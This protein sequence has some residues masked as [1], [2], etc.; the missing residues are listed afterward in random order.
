MTTTIDMALMALRVYSTKAAASG[1]DK[2]FNRP[3]I[4]TG[5]SEL[6][7]HVDQGDGFSY[8]VYRNGAEIVVAYAGTNEG[9][10]WLSNVDIALGLGST[11]VTKAA[12]AY[13]QARNQ[14]GPN[15]TFTGHSLGG[16]LAS[17][18]AVWFDRPAVVFDEAPF[19]ATA[20]N[21]IVMAATALAL[22]LSGYSVSALTDFLG[23]YVTG[24]AARE[25]KVTNHFL[26]G[27]ALA[28]LR[29]IW[30]TVVGQ[31]AMIQAN[32]IDVI[33]L[34]ASTV[35]HS[36]ALLTA[37]VL[38]NEFRLA[39]YASSKL[40]PLLMDKNLFAN[41]TQSDSENI[42]INLIR[43][44]QAAGAGVGKLTRLAAEVVKASQPNGLTLNDGTVTSD[45]HK[46]LIAFALQKYYEETPTSAGA[47]QP[48]FQD[49]AGGIS[50]DIA[51]VSTTFAKT[52]ASALAD[53]TSNGK[54]NLKDAK[55]FD[56]YLKNY[57]TDRSV[58]TAAES[59]L[60]QS[61]LPQ[62]R[63][64]LVQAGPLALTGIDTLN[65]GAF[66]LGGTGYD[67]LVGGS[68]TDLLVGGAGADLL[69][70]A[71]VCKKTRLALQ[72]KMGPKRPKHRF[73]KFL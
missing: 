38:S 47:S 45:L 39:T 41:S 34:D 30:P 26:E 43:G 15:I 67:T 57:L 42:L 11:Q 8:G 35:L 22:T 24:Y 60:I 13:L 25:A 28:A 16:G 68:K 62:M 55:G 1:I 17:I 40:L 65:R 59:A 73:Q 64:W 6:E 70:Y 12:I 69:R 2:E 51:N 52:F 58:F 54:L 66:M 53:N 27:E 9:V 46:T 4:P 49:V 72:P 63:D 29:A 3:A 56:Q 44:E 33:G 10:D 20:L 48:L 32:S 23:S 19:K 5:W 36:Q 18:M 61:L 71:R 21:P 37:L 50:F 14:Y 7:W 31:T